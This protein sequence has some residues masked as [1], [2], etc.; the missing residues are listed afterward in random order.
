MS[1]LVAFFADSLRQVFRGGRLYWSWVG[2]L[3]LVVLVGVAFYW[4]QL[5]AGP[6]HHGHERP[7]VVGRVHRQLHL[8]GGHC[9]RRGHAGD[10]RLRV[11]PG[12]RQARR[13]D[14]RRHRRGRG[15][16]VRPLR[17][18]GPGPAGPHVAHDPLGRAA[19]LP[20]LACWRG[21]SSSSP[22]TSCSTSRSPSTCSSAGIGGG[23]RARVCTFRPCWSRS[24]GRSR[25]TR[26]RRFSSRRTWPGRS[27]TPPCSD[28]A[29]WPRP[30]RRGRR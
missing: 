30:S 25:F 10:P 9:G 3:G 16:H 23:S 20:G 14:R 4:R 26:S 15:D 19:P 8:P 17:R 5:R 7:G 11:P 27:G 12:R 1:A 13:A 22:D 29:S 18:G 2:G 21:T 6:D 24:P 28:R